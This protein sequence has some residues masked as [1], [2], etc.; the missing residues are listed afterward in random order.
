MKLI[1][2]ENQNNLK[3][4]PNKVLIEDVFE[5]DKTIIKVH[6]EGDD[7]PYLYMVDTI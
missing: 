3:P 7:A 5:E 1:S 4:L 6:V 2:R